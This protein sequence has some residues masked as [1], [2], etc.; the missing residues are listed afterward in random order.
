MMC[1]CGC[2]GTVKA[3]LSP[4]TVI[5]IP[6][7]LAALSRRVYLLRFLPLLELDLLLSSPASSTSSWSSSN[8]SGLELVVLVEY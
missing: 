2:F 7:S 5:G 8:M 1:G 3:E 4:A 6:V